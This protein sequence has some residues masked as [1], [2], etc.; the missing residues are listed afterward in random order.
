[1]HTPPQ[2]QQQQGVP[3]FSEVFIKYAEFIKGIVY[4]VAVIISIVGLYY[5][6]QSEFQII[7]FEVR[8]LQTKVDKLER[9]EI[10]TRVATMEKEIEALKEAN[11]E[12]KQE[13][14]ETRER[15]RKLE[16]RRRR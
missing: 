5:A 2:Q 13:Y 4:L 14:R 9:K 8:S 15:M 6:Q 16:N 11:K 12:I 7:K 1:M 10:T 3:S